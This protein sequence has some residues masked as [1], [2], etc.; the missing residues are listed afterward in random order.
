MMQL[1]VHLHERLLHPLD[2]GGRGVDQALSVSQV[3]TETHDLIP[4]TKAA[5]QQAV[6]V[7][8]LEPLRVVDVR[9]PSRHVLDITRVDQQ[10]LEPVRFENLVDRKPVHARRL[11]RDRG[12]ANRRQP[13]GELVEIAADCSERANRVCRSVVRNRDHV[14]RRADI[15]PGRIWVDRGQPVRPPFA[16]LLLSHAWPRMVLSS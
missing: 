8:L 3:G 6:L 16:R 7:Q 2:M 11:H 10:H 13:L 1:D 15:D 9:L 4:G 5:A 12:D 14:R